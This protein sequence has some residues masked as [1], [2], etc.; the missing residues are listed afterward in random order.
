MKKRDQ[1]NTEAE[2]KS[3]NAPSDQ[4][5]SISPAD[6]K[7]RLKPTTLYLATIMSSG[8][9]VLIFFFLGQKML[10]LGVVALTI[11]A[12]LLFSLSR[13]LSAKRIK[14]DN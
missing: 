8:I 6:N 4:D 14:S 7:R 11:C 13:L 5:A 3:L 10:A 12:L 1:M 9:W 2:V